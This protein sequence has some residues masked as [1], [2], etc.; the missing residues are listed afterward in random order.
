M[1]GRGN[2]F[3]I[4]LFSGI[5]GLERLS[6]TLFHLCVA[7]F[8]TTIAQSTRVAMMG[9][10]YIVVQTIPLVVLSLYMGIWLDNTERRKV[11]PRALLVKVIGVSLTLFLSAMMLLFDVTVGLFLMIPVLIVLITLSAVTSCMH[12]VVRIATERIWV[13]LAANGDSCSSRFLVKC[14]SAMSISTDVGQVFGLVVF[15]RALSGEWDCDGVFVFCGIVVLVFT[16]LQYFL[17]R[18]VDKRC[19]PPE[20]ISIHGQRRTVRAGIVEYMSQKETPVGVCWAARSTFTAVWFAATVMEHSPISVLYKWLYF[21]TTISTSI[22]YMFGMTRIKSHLILIA[23]AG[24]EIVAIILASAPVLSA[25]FQVTGLKN[26]S[27]A[28]DIAE[29]TVAVSFGELTPAV[30][31]IATHVLLALALV[32]GT[33][34]DRAWNLTALQI[35]Q[36]GVPRASRGVVG[37][38]QSCLDYTALSFHGLLAIT[39]R[40]KEYVWTCALI[41][42][43]LSVFNLLI[44]FWWRHVR[45]GCSETVT[46]LR[47]RDLTVDLSYSNTGDM[48]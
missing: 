45:L 34:C 43:I 18:A 21:V 30:Y 28:L 35:Y 46:L 38:V 12:L 48:M 36:E 8:L 7:N 1:G 41:G 14:N 6:L 4:A 40:G 47:R 32:L 5:W 39:A 17:F 23:V 19:L 24:A 11:I 29:H 37:G 27:T 22:S 44:L 20:V 9:T 31:S 13:V 25:S 33:A 2:T 16:A 10:I 15:E 26:K 3:C 42:M